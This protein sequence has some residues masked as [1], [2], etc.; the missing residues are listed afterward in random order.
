MTDR[1]R[2]AMEEAPEKAAATSRPR[3]K[4]L[5]AG[6]AT[7]VALAAGAVLWANW[8]AQD[9]DVV[10]VLG[11]DYTTNMQVDEHGGYVYVTV[12]VNSDAGSVVVEVGDAGDNAEIREFLDTLDTLVPGE[13]VVELQ[14]SNLHFIVDGLAE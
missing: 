12:P 14:R 3:R 6:G 7:A 1:G 5:W 4:L 11:V 10:T 9:L 13:H 2:H 8:P